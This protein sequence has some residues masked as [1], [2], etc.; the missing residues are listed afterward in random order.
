MEKIMW[1]SKY[2]IGNKIID[3]QHQY[4][5]NLINEITEKRK[6]MDLE[7]IKRIFIELKKYSNI[8]F[9]DEELLM[10]EINYPKIEEHKEQHKVFVEEL[11]KI[12]KELMLENKYVSFEIIIFLSKWFINHILFMDKDF[13]NY[14]PKEL[15]SD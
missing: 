15:E 1:L 7:E 2:N 10:K 11:D 5:L 12:E 13:S 6:E 3:S 14:L 4:L 8:H 9:D